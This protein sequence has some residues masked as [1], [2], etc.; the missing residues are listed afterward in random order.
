MASFGGVFCLVLPSY[1][2]SGGIE[3][4]SQVQSLIPWFAE[5]FA[6]LRF[7]PTMF[8]AL[9]VGIALGIAQ[10]RR[11]LLLSCLMVPLPFLLHAINL[12]HDFLRGDP[13][14]KDLLKRMNLPE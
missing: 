9:A 1:L 11:W 5:S 6:N 14:F 3:R 2:A 12:S 10:P 13:R 8:L 7:L 4:P